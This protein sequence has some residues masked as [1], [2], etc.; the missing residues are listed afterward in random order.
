MK[1]S[2]CACGIG[3]VPVRH[4]GKGI[5]ILNT[6][7]RATTSTRWHFAFSAICICSV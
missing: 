2:A 3:S 7:H 4:S 6:S 1:T 5:S